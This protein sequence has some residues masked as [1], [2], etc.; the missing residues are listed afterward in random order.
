MNYEKKYKDALERA[1]EI[2]RNEDEKRFDMEWLFPELKEN[3]NERIRKEIIRILKGEMR[4]VS[5]EDTD[6]YIAWLEKQ[7]EKLDADEVIEWL[8]PYGCVVDG[9]VEQFKKD[10]GL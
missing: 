7:S 6:K 10:F 5:K 1:K 4:Y 2:H 8:K 3:E 9:I